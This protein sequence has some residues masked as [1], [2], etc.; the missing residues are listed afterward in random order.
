MHSTTKQPI[1]R[2]NWPNSIRWI[3]ISTMSAA[4]SW[5]QHSMPLLIMLDSSNVE[6]FPNT[7][8]PMLTAFGISW[9]SWA[10]DFEWKVSSF[11]TKL[12]T[13]SLWK[14]STAKS[15]NGS[16]VENWR[17]KKMWPKDWKQVQK[18][19]SAFSKAQTS[20]RQWFKSLMTEALF[21]YE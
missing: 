21:F 10:N 15:L 2:P 17:S 9:T 4:I 19:W 14:N 1:Q 16:P 3:S 5:K 20:A 11:S 8:N 7:T 12:R 6:W 13:R 18:P